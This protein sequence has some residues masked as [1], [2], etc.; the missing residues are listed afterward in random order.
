MFYPLLE[1]DGFS[2]TLTKVGL[3]RVRTS[4]RCPHTSLVVAS[5]SSTLAGPRSGVVTLLQ[6]Y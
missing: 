4:S 2:R 5:G 3:S 6:E 1:S